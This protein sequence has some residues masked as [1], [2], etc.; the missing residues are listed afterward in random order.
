MTASNLRHCDAMGRQE[1]PN[2]VRA[3]RR[4]A[5]GPSPIEGR[6]L[7]AAEDLDAATVVL[8]GR[9]GHRAP[10]LEEDGRDLV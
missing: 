4:V 10:A 5:V 1:P 9:R 6:G 7:F 2:D 3:D 8:T